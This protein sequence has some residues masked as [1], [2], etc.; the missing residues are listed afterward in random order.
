MQSRIERVTLYQN[1]PPKPGF[2]EPG[3]TMR[4]L[5]LPMSWGRAVARFPFSFSVLFSV[6][7]LNGCCVNNDH[8]VVGYTEV[9]DNN[10]EEDLRIGSVEIRSRSLPPPGSL[11]GPEW[12]WIPSRVSSPG[13]EARPVIPPR[14]WWGSPRRPV[15]LSR[16]WTPTAPELERLIR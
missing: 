12:F 10:P 11:P 2:S 16:G 4:Y 6:L 7:L 15:R 5:G 3:G 8:R 1:I 9:P 13:W 14:Y